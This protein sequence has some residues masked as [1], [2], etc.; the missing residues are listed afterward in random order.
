MLIDQFLPRFDAVESH[1]T[2]VSAPA[3]RVWAAIRTADFGTNGVVRALF[4]LRGVPAFLSA[5]RASLGRS[6]NLTPQAPLTIEAALKHGFVVLG[7]KP[8]R[9][10]LL[11]AAGR[12][13]GTPGSLSRIDSTTFS[14]FEEPGAAQAAWNFAVR[15]L[16][17]ERTM[18]TTETRVRCVDADS[19]WRFRLYWLFIR[20]FSGVIRLV[21]L[22]AIKRA[23]EEPLDARIGAQP[24]GGSAAG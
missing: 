14:S 11:G 24:A 12:F 17:G 18:L 3:E 22:R 8:G 2:I 5:P 9:E 16:V 23:A 20:P 7:E 15:P 6:R 19:R 10:L 4:A 13:W 1:T 21:M